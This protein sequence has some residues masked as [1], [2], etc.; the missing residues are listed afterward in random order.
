MREEGV[1]DAH[2]AQL[3]HHGAETMGRLAAGMAPP[4]DVETQAREE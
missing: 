2:Q 3:F 4:E 1:P